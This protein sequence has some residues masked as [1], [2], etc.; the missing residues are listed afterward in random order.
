MRRAV[1]VLASLLGPSPLL[2]AQAEWTLPA[3]RDCWEPMRRPVQHVG[4]PGYQF[5]TGVMW[6]GALV[7]GPLDVRDLPVLA[8][9]LAPLGENALHFTVGFGEPL[10]IVDRQGTNHP[11]LARWLE[12]GRLPIPVVETRDGDLLW[13]ETVFAHLLG[14]AMADGMEPRPD[15]VLVTHVQFEVENHGAAPAIAHLWLHFGTPASVRFGYKC[16]Q[17]PELAPSIAFTFQPPFGERDG[18]VR[19]VLPPPARGELHEHDEVAAS[20]AGAAPVP[21]AIEWTVELS[22]G[23]RAEMRLVLPYGWVAPE[24]A[25]EL[26]ALDPAREKAAVSAYWRRV[27]DGPG[28][29]YTPDPWIDDYLAAIPVQMAQQV[30]YRHRSD[31]WMYK[32]SPNHYES[33]WPCNAAK[34]LPA[35]TLRGRADLERAVLS[36]FLASQTADVGRLARANM[37]HGEALAGEGYAEVSGFLGN[38]GGWTANTLLLS[39]GL[40]MW[41]MARHYRTTRD[42]AWLGTGPGSPLEAMLAAFDWVAAQ[43]RRTMREEDGV[44]VAHWGLLPAASAHDWLAGS[45]IFNDTYCIYGMAEVVRLAR[46]IAHPRAAELASELAGYRACLHDAYAAATGRASPVPMPDGSL[47]P[48]VPRLVAEL[49]WRGIDWTYTGYGPLRAGAWGAFD[50]FDPLVEDALAFLE[51][52]MPKGEGP[53]FSLSPAS[54]EIADLN[55]ADISDPAADRHHLWRHYVEYE[56][57]WPIGGHLFLARDDLPRFFEWLFHN[58]AVVVHRDWRVG[59]ESLDGVPSCAPGDGERWQA[60][61]AMFVNER[62]GLGGTTE[63]LWLL[64]AIPR[65]WLAPRAAF[66]VREMGTAFGGTVDLAAEVAPDG[67]S[68]AVA[69]RLSALRV[70]PA[71]LKLRLRSG[72]GRPLVAATIDGEPLAVESGDLVTLPVV[73]DGRMEVVGRF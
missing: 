21:R 29:I 32:T 47:L 42:D 3:A 17:R 61:R 49:D 41:A 68:L 5:Q 12:E 8:E 20:P 10:R 4:V 37:G 52:G 44:R 70:R 33:Y 55:W 64:Q 46:E 72:D 9:E 56:T 67:R 59:V 30:A 27:I 60:M 58:L 36:G 16:A 6:N 40:G 51:T 45:T 22:P 31:R 53:Y 48:Y 14:R 73:L 26:L 23:A 43:R 1:L 65:A 19:F 13:R 2:A 66:G 18:L 35:F 15:D 71:A 34:A 54:M 63:E 28:Q 11:D 50:P 38:F 69:V 25:H 57:M 39:H 24:V 62:G 7:C